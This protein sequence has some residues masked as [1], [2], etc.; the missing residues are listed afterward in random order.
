MKIKN[1]L[2]LFCTTVLLTMMVSIC[3]SQMVNILCNKQ[4]LSKN[5]ELRFS[6]RTKDEI[7]REEVERISWSTIYPFAEKE[8]EVIYTTINEDIKKV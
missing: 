1:I 8:N 7:F 3:T 6:S 4:I 5:A 2:M